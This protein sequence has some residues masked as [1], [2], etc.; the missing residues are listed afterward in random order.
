M[1]KYGNGSYTATKRLVDIE[2]LKDSTGKSACGQ[3]TKSTVCGLEDEICQ[4]GW[5]ERCHKRSHW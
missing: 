2:V 1:I 3:C 5:S 4:K